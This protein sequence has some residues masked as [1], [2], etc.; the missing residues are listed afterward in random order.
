MTPTR[1]LAWFT[2]QSVRRGLDAGTDVNGI[3]WAWWDT[4]TG[5]RRD[6][7]VTGS[8]LDSVLDA[9]AALWA[10]LVYLPVTHWAF[11]GSRSAP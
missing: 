11:G 10:T 2:E 1:P 9:F 6:A 4:A 5:T 8:Y 3:P 7:V